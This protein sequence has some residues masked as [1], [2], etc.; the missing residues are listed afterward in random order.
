MRI[1]S[2]LISL[3]ILL[4]S[5]SNS[6]KGEIDCSTIFIVPPSILLKITNAN[7]TNL[8]ENET[9]IG[10]EI[11]IEINEEIHKNVVNQNIESLKNLIIIPLN[12][13]ETE[14]EYKINLSEIETDTLN[15]N[16]SLNEGACGIL[17]TKP[18]S[19][20]YNGNTITIED[21]NGDYLITVV[22]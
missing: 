5:C 7:G 18:N 6:D 19:A 22:K 1:S 13:T 11:T 8:I 16:V 12:S 9:Y 3:F 10:S 20:V 17:I 2:L 14:R 21:Y 15:L 4:T